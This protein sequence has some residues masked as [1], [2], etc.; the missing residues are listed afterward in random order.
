[1]H[2]RKR[3]KSGS[4]RPIKKSIPTWL[5]YKPKEIEILITKFSKD[6]K[7]SSETGLFLR[8][9]YGIPNVK[10]VCGKSITEIMKENKLLPELPDDLT[11]LIRKS[12]L[13]R[14]HLEENNKDQTANRGLT[15]TESKIK[16]LVKYYKKTGKLSSDWK[17]DPSRAGFFMK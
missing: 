4:K 1:M 8:D 13:V 17:Y 7:S 5:S 9:N 14:K 16:R 10:L 2:S 11:A 12:V 15:L 3:G 6:G